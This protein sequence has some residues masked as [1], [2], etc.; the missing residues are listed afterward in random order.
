MAGVRSYSVAN[1][2]GIAL[3]SGGIEA[4]MNINDLPRHVCFL[5][6]QNMT[7][8]KGLAMVARVSQVT[9]LPTS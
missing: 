3:Q 2:I 9:R 8:M 5:I 1:S 4:A 7:Y 6:A